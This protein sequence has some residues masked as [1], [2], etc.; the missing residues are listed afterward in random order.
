MAIADDCSWHIATGAS[1][2][3]S[4]H[5]DDRRRSPPRSLT[6]LYTCGSR[7]IRA[8]WQVGRHRPRP[9]VGVSRRHDGSLVRFRL[10]RLGAWDSHL[11]LRLLTDD[12]FCRRLARDAT[13]P[14]RSFKTTAG[15]VRQ[16]GVSS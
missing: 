13:D 8:R 4:D 14:E 11:T 10:S 9:L 5:S 7:P 3:L 6:Q 1:R 15:A 16:L 12:I 2:T